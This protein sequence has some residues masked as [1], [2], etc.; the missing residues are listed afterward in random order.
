MNK[1]PNENARF[2]DHLKDLKGLQTDAQLAAKLGLNPPSISKLR[3]KHLDIGDSLIITI[4]EEFGLS[5]R[6]IKGHLNLPSLK[7]FNA[8][9]RAD[10]GQMVAQC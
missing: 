3:H 6:D 9:R 2:L 8:V 5:I 1:T 7:S 10:S 4:H